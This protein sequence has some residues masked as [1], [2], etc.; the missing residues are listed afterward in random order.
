MLHAVA[1]AAGRSVHK[2]I[3][4]PNHFA[5]MKP[6]NAFVLS[7][8]P[9]A[10]ASLLFFSGCSKQV[11][12]PDHCSQ[13]VSPVVDAKSGVQAFLRAKNVG[14]E[15]TFTVCGSGLKLIPDEKQEVLYDC[16]HTC[17][18]L[19]MGLLDAEGAKC[20]KVREMANET[21]VNRIRTSHIAAPVLVLEF[22]ASF[23]ECEPTSRPTFEYDGGTK[24]WSM[25]GASGG[26]KWWED[27]KDCN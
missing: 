16:P 15:F 12:A 23:K 13:A 6:F 25:S 21:Y 1:P 24:H 22:P 9:A 11:D 19:D 2:L 7:V 8:G 20:S 3:S 14:S 5:P 18:A 17:G 4:S 10:I 27:N 26:I